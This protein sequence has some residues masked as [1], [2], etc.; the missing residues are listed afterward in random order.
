LVFFFFFF[1]FF[2]FLVVSSRGGGVFERFF[3]KVVFI[4]RSIEC[5]CGLSRPKKK[6]IDFFFDE[7][8]TKNSF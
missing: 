3:P 1:F 6:K 8:K 5:V 4:R 2:F 7:S